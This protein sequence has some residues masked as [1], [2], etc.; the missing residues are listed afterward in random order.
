MG[1]LSIAGG[2]ENATATS[3]HST[4][5]FHTRSPH[6]PASPVLDIYPREESICPR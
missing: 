3:K 2:N 1:I 6:D 4:A 5:Q